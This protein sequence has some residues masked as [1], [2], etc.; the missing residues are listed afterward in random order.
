MLYMCMYILFLGVSY[1]DITLWWVH[2]KDL[3]LY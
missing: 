3:T 1:L 2:L